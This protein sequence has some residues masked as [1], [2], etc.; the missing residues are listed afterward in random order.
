V[1]TAVTITNAGTPK[2]DVV[3]TVGDVMVGGVPVSVGLDGVTVGPQTVPADQLQQ[4]TAQ[5]NA[6]LAAA[7]ITVGTLAPAIKTTAK[8]ETVTATAA[9]VTIDQPGPPEQ[10]VRHNLGNVFVDN[11]AIPSLP[12]AEAPLVGNPVGNPAD[13]LTGVSAPA[14]AASSGFAP[15]APAGTGSTAAAASTSASG[16]SGAASSAAP[17]GSS[18][19]DATLGPVNLAGQSLKPKWLLAMY[20]VW[21][22][23]M[24]GTGASVWW[25][26][27]ARRAG[28]LSA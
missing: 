26:R 7:G 5:L 21:Q 9:T 19:P 18:S 28:A 24:L 11:L 14:G 4:A 2:A 23:V 1:H 20:V 3:T 15:I 22:L 8:Q 12:A 13:G 25:W 16:A 17:A 27:S 10:T 6:I